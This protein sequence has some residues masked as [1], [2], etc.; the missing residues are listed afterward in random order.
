MNK[1]LQSSMLVALGAA[2][3][4]VIGMAIARD[5]GQGADAPHFGHKN[6]RNP[7]SSDSPHGS[8]SSSPNAGRE[9]RLEYP[10][11]IAEES[12][13]S[14][15]VSNWTRKGGMSEGIVILAS[16]IENL[17]PENVEGL[18][19]GM[20]SV[21]AQ[22]AD[23]NFEGRILWEKIGEIDGARRMGDSIPPHPDDPPGWGVGHCLEG[24]AIADPEA[25]QS[26]FAA[27]EEGRF[28]QTLVSHAL[29]GLSR[30]QPL[31]AADFLVSLPLEQQLADAQRN[32]YMLVQNGGGE[33][34]D[35][36]IRGLE[37]REA[38]D[39][40]RTAFNNV[41]E[42]MIDRDCGHAAEWLSGEVASSYFDASRRTRFAAAWG[43]RDPE[44]AADWATSDSENLELLPRIIASCPESRFN[45]MAI[46]L[47]QHDTAE[48]Y[49]TASIAFAGRI[50]S[51]DPES[52]R[53]WRAAAEE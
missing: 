53:R 37:D 30:K 15:V 22:G 1:V 45:D 20:E 11:P 33:A 5:H 34:A 25:V 36:W 17:R 31:E 44:A 6:S 29:T 28:K 51:S 26:W 39:E 13:E 52:A 40:A 12:I 21:Q 42:R 27:L 41:F 46:W 9:R 24:W 23:L 47:S 7:T 43:G 35:R 48:F 3:G 10:K 18:I 50:E 32:A 2:G 8:R 38:Q 16:I 19:A 14:L 4:V 49:G